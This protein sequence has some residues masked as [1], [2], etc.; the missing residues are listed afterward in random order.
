MNKT[1]FSDDITTNG[2]TLH[3]YRTG[4]MNHPTIICLHGITDN[5]LCWTRFAE[6]MQDEF[7]VIMLDARGHG[8]S[9]APLTGY[10]PADHAADVMGLIEVLKLHQ[11][12]LIGHSMGGLTIAQFLVMYPKVAR[13]AIL[14]DPPWVLPAVAPVVVAG[15]AGWREQLGKDQQR[16]VEV[17]VAKGREQ[18]PTWHEAE[19]RPWAES[20]KQ[21][22]L[23]AFEV[24]SEESLQAWPEQVPHF[25]IPTLLLTAE[26]SLGAVTQPDIAQQAVALS[27]NLHTKQIPQAGHSIRREQLEGYIQIVRQF[28]S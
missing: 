13:C 8:R 7:D 18:N 5:G 27:P 4:K 15:L 14:E 6:A 1:W 20:K 9:A 28:I 2:L 11:P 19:F 26:P 12:I 25:A 23:Q 17:F 3:Y 10:T 22:S 16:A 21:V 24:I